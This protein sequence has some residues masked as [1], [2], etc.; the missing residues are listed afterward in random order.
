MDVSSITW[1]KVRMDLSKF[2]V[3]KT[4]EP[5][6]RLALLA[7]QTHSLCQCTRETQVAW[8]ISHNITRQTVF[9][10]IPSSDHVT[11][12]I[13]VDLSGDNEH[14]RNPSMSLSCKYIKCSISN[15]QL[16]PLL[17]IIVKCGIPISQWAWLYQAVWEVSID[18][19]ALWINVG[20]HRWRADG[21]H[22]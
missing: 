11:L 22:C 17:A 10:E 15:K 4:A 19:I 8:I 2:C 21:D 13:L 5:Q 12:E 14:L 1:H 6:D 3:H 20:V 9:Q 7:L 18:K 16:S